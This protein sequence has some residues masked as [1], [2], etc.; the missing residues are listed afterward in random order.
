ME[1]QAQDI[2]ELTQVASVTQVNS[3]MQSGDMS[4]NAVVEKANTVSSYKTEQHDSVFAEYKEKET[5]FKQYLAN[6]QRNKDIKSAL[7]QEIIDL[8]N[9]QSEM[10]N[11]GTGTAKELTSISKDIL[12]KQSLI[13]SYENAFNG[14]INSTEVF[15]V[16]LYLRS[17]KATTAA[18]EVVKNY[19]VNVENQFLESG[20][21]QLRKVL[22]A[23]IKDRSAHPYMH[24]EL[25]FKPVSE[26]LA[27][28]L[29]Q[30]ILASY[31]KNNSDECSKQISHDLSVYSG[32]DFGIIDKSMVGS[33]IKLAELRAKHKL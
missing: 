6:I 2:N 14:E 20:I 28:K 26:V 5:E 31:N 19:R 4:Q 8:K 12:A 16:E 23:Q 9:Q 29:G 32:L 1:L 27:E 18:L 22:I 15:Q 17:S 33:P 21:E 3:I 24:D 7:E 10:I 25:S 30:M 13:D 11:K